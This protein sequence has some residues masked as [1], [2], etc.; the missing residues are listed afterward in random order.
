MLGRVVKRAIDVAGSTL[1]MLLLSP[2]GVVISLII[3]LDS[4]GPV[5]YR[6]PRVGKKGHPFLCHK[7]RTMVAN[8]DGLKPGLRSF[9]ERRGAT[10]KITKDPRITRAGRWLRKYSLDELPQFWNVFRGEMSLVGPRPHPL[11][12]Y[13]QYD[14]KHLRRLDVT[15]GLTGLWQIAARRN[16]SF[17]D[18]VSLDLEYIENWS[19]WLDLKLITRT[20]PA[21]LGGTGV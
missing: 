10:F 16:T 11:D 1:A 17:E 6:A 14:L 9:N 7:F 19:V 18:N 13:A 15:P 2:L 12:D 4:P 20:V 21:V 8:A 3:K 5:F